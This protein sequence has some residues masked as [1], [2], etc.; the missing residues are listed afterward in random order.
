MLQHIMFQTQLEHVIKCVRSVLSFQ[1]LVGVGRSAG[2]CLHAAGVLLD[3]NEHR[4]AFALTSLRKVVDI[5]H[6]VGV[7]RGVGGWAVGQCIEVFWG[8]LVWS[9]LSPHPFRFE[10]AH[11]PT[12]CKPKFTNGGWC[13]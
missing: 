4:C 2:G 10:L 12:I 11:P 3:E 7:S 1:S 13:G 5:W 6:M 8:G 9:E